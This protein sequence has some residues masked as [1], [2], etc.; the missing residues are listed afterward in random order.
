MK[1]FGLVLIAAAIALVILF[2]PGQGGE[3]SRLVSGPV[4]SAIFP[5]VVLALFT[6][7]V[8]TLVA[9]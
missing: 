1:I 8:A 2:R 6:F 5:T 3:E 9:G 7:G 4:T